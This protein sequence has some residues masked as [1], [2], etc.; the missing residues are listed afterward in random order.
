MLYVAAQLSP[1][2]HLSNKMFRNVVQDQRASHIIWTRGAMEVTGQYFS[3]T[4]GG[5][6]PRL[7][8]KWAFFQASFFLDLRLHFVQLAQTWLAHHYHVAFII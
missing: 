7:C 3:T 1:V 8:C 5:N 6:C 4:Y 2:M